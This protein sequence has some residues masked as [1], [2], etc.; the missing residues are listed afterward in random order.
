MAELR[1]Y[2]FEALLTRM[3]RELDEHDRPPARIRSQ[4]HRSSLAHGPYASPFAM[5]PVGPTGAHP[6]RG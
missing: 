3:F 1:P 4:H 2:P 5:R 6:E